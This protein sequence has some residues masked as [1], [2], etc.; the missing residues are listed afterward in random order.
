MCLQYVKDYEKEQK[1]TSRQ[2]ESKWQLPATTEAGIT[3]DSPCENKKSSSSEREA[4]YNSSPT[5]GEVI[6]RSI[7]QTGNPAQDMLDLLLGPLLRKTI[8]KEEKSKSSVESVVVT[9]EFMRQSQNEIVGEEMVP[10]V[11]K[12]NTLKDKVAM[13][14]D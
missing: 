12:R 4:L 1:K 5:T 13:L 14:L 7:T 6:P 10:L 2:C 3:L 11:K 8:E 9:H